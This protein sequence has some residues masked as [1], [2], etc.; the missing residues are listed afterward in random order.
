MTTM[1]A[2]N[3]FLWGVA[4]AAY[5]VEGGY[6]ADGKGR[7]NW[8][9][10]TNE[11]QVT[12]AFIDK[13]HT[14]NVAI[15]FYE[16]SQYLQD[17]ALMKQLGVNAYRF[18]IAWSRI[19]PNG[20]GEINPKGV[21]YYHQLIDDLLAND[22]EPVVTNFHWDLPYQL[23]EKGGW[24]NSDSVQ[25]YAEYA[26]VLFANYGDR[27]KKFITFNEPFI[28]LFFIDLLAH[29]AIAKANPYAISNETYGKQAE[30][31]H[32]LLLA[33]AIATQNYHQLNLGGV[34]GITLSFTPTIPLDANNAEDVQAATVFDGLHNRWFLDAMYKGKYPD[35]IVKLHQQYNPAFQVSAEEMQLIA[36]HKPDFIGVNFYA[37]AYIKADASAPYGAEWFS[38]NPDEVKMFNGPVRPEYLY[39]LLVWIKNEYGNPT[40]YI[41][42]NGAGFGAADEQLDGNIVRDPLRTD[43]IQRHIDSAMQAKRDGVDLRG[44]FLWSF[45]DNFEWVFG[46]DKRFGIVYVD[47]D[48][49]R[50]TPKQSFYA[51]QQIINE[52][53]SK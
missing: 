51:Y 4:S 15:N 24:G 40:I 32:H 17:I 41:T 36:A 34:I 50:R 20:I 12:Q 29:N 9:V 47:F 38:T 42:E 14:G 11:Y 21:A 27:V 43:Y 5:Q 49:Q 18:S 39:Q 37:P 10:Y 30:A 45:C 6:Q 35:D 33:S 52:T 16:R 46:Y 44:Y 31:V 8:D 19:L 3:K 53:P 7:S 13:Q 2:Q 22:I 23:Q 26:D 25:W 48:S 1:F 28:Y